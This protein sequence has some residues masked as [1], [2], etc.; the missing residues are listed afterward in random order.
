[1]SY[2]RGYGQFTLG[3]DMRSV[4]GAPI[5]AAV[6]VL[7]LSSLACQAG[8]LG[9]GPVD[10]AQVTVGSG[11]VPSDLQH[12]P[13]SGN[14]DRYMA[15]LKPRN[16]EAY[17]ALQDTWVQLQKEG[18]KSAAIALYSTGQAG[19][20]AR[21]GTAAGRNLGNLVVSFSDD[22]AAAAAYQRG[23]FGFPTPAS[24]EQV[25][26]VSLGVATGLSENSWVAQRSVGGRN[27]YVAWWQDHA[28]ATFLVSADL[29]TT[30]SRR[31]AEAVEARIR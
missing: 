16:K 21:M 15:Q 5:G 1:M 20:L 22:H 14:L 12:C 10:P 4:L 23:I 13:A 18:A 3:A 26:G 28:V 27:L 31:A 8:S 9:S 30:E 19:C 25:P 6:L 11:E 17:Q 24:D 29:D 2:R 7:V